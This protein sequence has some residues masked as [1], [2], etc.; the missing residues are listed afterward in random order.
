V[1]KYPVWK[2]VRLSVTAALGFSDA[3]LRLAI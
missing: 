1:T 3:P 2:M